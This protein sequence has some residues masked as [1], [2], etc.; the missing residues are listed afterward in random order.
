MIDT[1]KL[2]I[3]PSQFK[4]HKPYDFVPYA[5]LVYQNKAIKT[6]LNKKYNSKNSS[7]FPRITLMRRKNLE[8]RSEIM[9]TIEFSVPKLLFGNN[10]EELQQKDFAEIITVLKNRL[11]KMGIEIQPKDLM[12][13]D[14]I[15]VHY[16]KNIKICDGSTPYSYIQK[17]K[18]IMTPSRMDNN[19]TNYRNA[20]LSYKY[21]CNSHEILFYDKVQDLINSE[22]VSKKRSIDPQNYFNIKLLDKIRTKRKKF[23]VLR[24]EVRLNT[25]AKMKQL[26]TALAIKNNLTF[27]KLF[28][29]HLSKKILLHYISELEH[30]R[31]AL[32]DFK[33]IN[34]KDL[35]STIK[36]YNPTMTS[37]QILQFFGFKK[38]LE[39]MSL[40]ELKKIIS[41]N[42]QRNW[43]R[44]MQ[45]V[46]KVYVPT[47]QNNFE[48]I[49]KKITAK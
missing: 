43:M 39:T 20:G 15:T 3:P 47:K 36:L 38:A 41:K 5:D 1:I 19:I 18:E 30:K 48:I 49:R 28:K 13:A 9:M 37:K 34:D 45:E 44:F 42:N 2:L 11:T 7:Y 32:V 46:E 40:D 14:V 26:F 27:E 24:M 10:L 6:V 16:S 4:I 35:L 23:E 25:R 8:G 12:F 17:I 31:S 29:I 21:H 33:S 22:S